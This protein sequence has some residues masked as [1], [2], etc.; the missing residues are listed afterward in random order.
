MANIE[1]YLNYL[2]EKTDNIDYLKLLENKI[3]AEN[4][5]ACAAHGGKPR[6]CRRLGARNFYKSLE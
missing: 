4:L 2:I 6:R 5:L 3:S 1:K